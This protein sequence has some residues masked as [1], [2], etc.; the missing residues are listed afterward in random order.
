VLYYIPNYKL[1][2]PISISFFQSHFLRLITINLYMNNFHFEV[3]KPRAVSD[4]NHDTK[5][6]RHI[7]NGIVAITTYFQI[8]KNLYSRL[9]IQI[10]YPKCNSKLLA[11]VTKTRKFFLFINIMQNINSA[12]LIF[13]LNQLMQKVLAF[14]TLHI[15]FLNNNKTVTSISHLKLNTSRSFCNSSLF[16][17]HSEF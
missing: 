9:S 10:K 4:N 2:I 16:Y 17:Q 8:L 1:Y 7:V 3:M 12:G 11:M 5:N 14:N 6:L 13:S 15:T